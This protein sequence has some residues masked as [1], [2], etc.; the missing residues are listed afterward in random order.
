MVGGDS[1]A[2]FVRYFVASSVIVRSAPASAIV[3]SAT[4][5][6]VI[7]RS[8]GATAPSNAKSI[9]RATAAR[10]LLRR[11]NQRVVLRKRAAKIAAA[12][13]KL[14]QKM[15]N[16]SQV[17]KLRPGKDECGSRAEHRFLHG[18]AVAD[19]WSRAGEIRAPAG[20]RVQSRE[21]GVA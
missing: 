8:V 15:S 21:R 1:R 2:V 9:P 5:V 11:W 12:A 3:K 14:I 17:A 18:S 19:E 16:V 7:T 20:Q 10:T 6:T 4:F 13:G